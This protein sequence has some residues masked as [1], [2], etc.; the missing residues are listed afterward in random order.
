MAESIKAG[1]RR[2]LNRLLRGA[3]IHVART[4][5]VFEMDGLLARAA[6]RGVAIKTWIDV[7]A[8]DG[9]WS[10]GARRHFPHAQFLLFEP[11]AEHQPALTRL[12]QAEGFQC[13]AAVAGAAPGVAQFLVDPALDG[14]AVA[15][16]GTPGT[17]P[18]PVET[19][20]ATVR[21]RALPGPYG[22]KLDTHGYE[23]AVLAGAT[24]VMANV[25]LLIVEAYNFSLTPDSLRFHELCAWLE[26]RGF[27]CCD[28]ADPM[29]RPRDGAFWQVDLAFER[30]NAPVFGSDSYE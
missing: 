29:R 22:L 2:F 23:L 10:L 14:S 4:E 26:A 6:G 13:V 24:D 21:T 25:N 15:P 20:D 17:R 28:I 5:R 27:R 16:A 18:V 19:I 7:G 1:A 8:S 12:Q 3:G 9:Q 11:L 30:A